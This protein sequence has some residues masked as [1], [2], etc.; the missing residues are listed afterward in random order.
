MFIH[1]FPVDHGARE[2]VQKAVV[3]LL[4]GNMTE[5]A[6]NDLNQAIADAISKSHSVFIIGIP[7]KN[8]LVETQLLLSKLNRIPASNKLFARNSFHDLLNSTLVLD[9]AEKICT[10][11]VWLSHFS[12][13]SHFLIR[14]LDSVI[15]NRI[16]CFILVLLFCLHGKIISSLNLK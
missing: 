3:M 13:R 12:A 10:G 16:A 14:Y 2:G 1:L 8:L 5:K 4:G 15:C 7:E 11:M 6:I 9:F